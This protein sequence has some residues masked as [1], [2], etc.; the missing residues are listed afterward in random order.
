M[1]AVGPGENGGVLGW[2]GVAE[3]GR[4]LV[5]SG[6]LLWESETFRGPS[7]SC[8]ACSHA[9]FASCIRRLMDLPLTLSLNE[10]V[11]E[12]RTLLEVVPKW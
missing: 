1:R 4:L 9:G 8:P 6:G 11:P 2:I 10:P 7:I 5:S 3:G 12:I